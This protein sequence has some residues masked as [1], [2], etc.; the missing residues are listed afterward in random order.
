[1]RLLVMVGRALLVGVGMFS[2]VA[3]AAPGSYFVRT[4]TTGG[5]LI[6]DGATSIAYARNNSH[7]VALGSADL[8]SGQLKEFVSAIDPQNSNSIW[9]DFGDTVTVIGVSEPTVISMTLNVTG[10]LAGPVPQARSW[11]MIGQ[12]GFECQPL[13]CLFPQPIVDQDQQLWFSPPDKVVGYMLTVQVQLTPEDPT[14]SFQAGMQ[15]IA[16]AG[17]T[18]DFGN[19]AALALVLPAGL[20]FTSASGVLL[21]APIPEP[22]IVVLFAIGAPLLAWRRRWRAREG[23]R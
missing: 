11:I 3:L 10:T 2:A 23:K 21:S 5:E 18:A 13:V 17:G 7:G 1:M 14:F 8:A 15:L 12:G 4:N 16:I 19:S 20:S 6:V 9:V 22:P